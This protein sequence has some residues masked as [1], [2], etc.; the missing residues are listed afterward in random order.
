MWFWVGWSLADTTT[1]DLKEQY[2]VRLEQGLDAFVIVDGL[3][4]V[5][6][7]SKAKLVTFLTKKLNQAG[8]IKED[9]FFMPSD[10]NG[11]TQGYVSNIQSRRDSR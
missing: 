1:I 6:E 9:G 3:P 11:Q 4:T 8:K 5:P 7:A 2:D 10:D